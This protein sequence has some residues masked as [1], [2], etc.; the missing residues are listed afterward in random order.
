MLDQQFLRN[1]YKSIG[2]RLKPRGY[3]F[4][5]SAYEGLE[6]RRKRIQ[7]DTESARS[8]KKQLSSQIGA[9]KASGAD[10]SELMAE[11]DRVG[12]QQDSL[13]Q[14]FAE[15]QEELHVLVSEIPNLAHDSVPVG[16]SEDDNEEVRR[17]GEVRKFDFNPIDH[18][19]IGER[20]GMLD[21][22]LGAKLASARFVLIRNQLAA[23]HRAISQMMLDIHTREHGYEEVNPPFIVNAG[24][25][26]GTGQLPKFEDDQFRLDDARDFYLIPTAEVPL[27]N[28]VKERIVDPSELPMKFVAHTP[29]FRK[30]AG[31]YGKDTRG[32]IRQHQFEKVELVHIVRPEDSYAALEE[33]TSN[34][35]RILKLLGLPYRVIVLC[36]GDMGFGAA[37]TYDIEVW[38][39]GQQKYR[40]ISS[41]SNCEGFQARRMKAR[42]RNPD[43]RRPEPVHTLNGSGLAVGRTFIAILENYQNED[44]SVDI[45]D[46]LVPYMGGI[47]R[48]EA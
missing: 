11:V 18:V 44:G 4:D 34:A 5:E 41:C 19:S 45:P 25:L 37:K 36:T 48:I 2:A 17:V 20:L 32:M 29:C 3:D 8:R 9:A 21:F 16:Q 47:E 22:E 6:T 28:I 7:S 15:I 42:W 30:E 1:E 10:V 24:I 40:E 27:T 31:S 43:T 26:Y 13:E 33:L 23:L 35:E 46:V 39:P 12:A 14:Q 38:L